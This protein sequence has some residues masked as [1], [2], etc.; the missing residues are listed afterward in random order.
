MAYFVSYVGMKVASRLHKKFTNN[1][2]ITRSEGTIETFGDL[3]HSTN[4]DSIMITY[5]SAKFELCGFR[6]MRWLDHYLRL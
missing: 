5:E 4:L 3:P 1:A 6:I 2:Y